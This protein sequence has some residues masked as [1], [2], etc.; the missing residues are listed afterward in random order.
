MREI[1][2]DGKMMGSKEEMHDHLK[3][4]FNLPYYYARNLDSLYQIL[5]KESDPIKVE[6]INSGSIA[7]GYGDAL[8][9][10]LKDLALKNSN[11]IIEI[12]D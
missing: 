3:S 2:I 12:K 4:R 9:L 10:L 1:V 11:Y 8:I 5:L 7:L 6:L